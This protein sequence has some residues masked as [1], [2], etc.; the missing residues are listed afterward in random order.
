MF[1]SYINYFVSRNENILISS[2]L[3]WTTSITI[4]LHIH[5]TLVGG[6]EEIQLAVE[7]L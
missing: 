5:N 7:V 3:L 2:D 1:A 4:T 6:C